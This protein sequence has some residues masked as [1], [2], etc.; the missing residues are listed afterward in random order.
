MKRL[1]VEQPEN[2]M[3]VMAEFFE[4]RATELGQ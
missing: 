2:P 3:R 1:A 4:Q